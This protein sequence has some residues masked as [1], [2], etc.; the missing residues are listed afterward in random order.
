MTD[1]IIS[2]DN[3]LTALQQQTLSAVVDVII[4]GSEDGRMPS[5][6]ELDIAAYLNDKAADLLTALAGALDGFD[7]GFATMDFSTRLEIV[8]SFSESQTELFNGLLFHTYCCYYQ[9]ARALKGIGL[10]GGPPFPQ[11]NTVIQGDLS[12]LDSVSDRAQGYRKV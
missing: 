8:R 6:Q 7:E 4:P 11:G 2:T 3:P 10:A 12:L 5:A 1:N 9:D